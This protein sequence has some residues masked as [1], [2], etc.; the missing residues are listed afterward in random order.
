MKRTYVF[1][2]QDILEHSIGMADLFSNYPPL[3]DPEEVR[4]YASACIYSANCNVH[5]CFTCIYIYIYIDC[6]DL[7]ESMHACTV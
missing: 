7:I 1:R 6:L 3:K 2:R 4:Q 5:K